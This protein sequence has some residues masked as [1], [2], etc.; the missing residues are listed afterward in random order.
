MPIRRFPPTVELA[1]GADVV[2]VQTMASQADNLDGLNG[3]VTASGLYAR[4]SAG[5]LRP[6]TMDLATHA[7]TNI[8]YEHH[9]IHD[10]SSYMHHEV[11][12]LAINNVRDIQITTPNTTN[13]KHIFY[14]IACESET[15]V[16][17]Y[18]NVN[19]ILAGTAITPRNRCRNVADAAGLTLKYI[20]NVSVANANLD[21]AVAAA[22]LIDHHIIGAKKEAGTHDHKTEIILKQNEDYCM[23]LIANVAGYVNYNLDWYGHTNRT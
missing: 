3:L 17:L 2:D 21:T 7:L 9:E 10:G 20:D 18:E 1:S 5:T 11:V 8:S 6:L 14:S 13:W 22:T 19:I 12:D 15:E 16:Y 23:R 4:G